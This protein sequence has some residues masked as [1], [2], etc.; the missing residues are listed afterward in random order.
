MSLCIEK[1]CNII[2]ILLWYTTF[3]DHFGNLLWYSESLNGAG[4]L[5]EVAHLS[6]HRIAL[7]R[8]CSNPTSEEWYDL[9]THDTQ[10]F[11]TYRCT[12]YFT[13]LRIKFAICVFHQV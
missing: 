5:F 12:Y 7:E 13:T 8:L 1:C 10:N 4:V 3:E 2:I 11:N 6:S 9:L